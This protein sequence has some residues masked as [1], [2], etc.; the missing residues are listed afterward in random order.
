MDI[1]KMM[2]SLLIVCT[3]TLATFGL[4]SKY[5]ASYKERA[6]LFRS[7]NNAVR[8]V[9]CHQLSLAMIFIY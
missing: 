5:R 1:C 2:W 9:N 3:L 7:E 8:V 4:A 6:N